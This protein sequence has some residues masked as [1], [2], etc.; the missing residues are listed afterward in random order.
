MSDAII[1]REDRASVPVE[2][3]PVKPLVNIGAGD[4]DKSMLEGATI[5]N[6]TIG[7]IGEQ[8][9]VKDGGQVLTAEAV[10]AQEM[11]KKAKADDTKENISEALKDA[12]IPGRKLCKNISDT[13]DKAAG[14][15]GR[16]RSS[17][18]DEAV[19]SILNKGS[20]EDADV[21]MSK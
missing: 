7:H 11:L 4:V 15:G 8:I 16:S 12:F 13:M 19:N 3:K 6:S 14:L 10:A 2:T 1:T 5:E 18:F 20:K 17:R 9:D 21:E